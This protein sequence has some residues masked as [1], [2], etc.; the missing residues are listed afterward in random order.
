MPILDMGT[1][2]TA[3]VVGPCVGLPALKGQAAEKKVLMGNRLLVFSVQLC[4]VL[5][6]ERHYFSIENPLGSWTWA[7][8]A[9][10]RLHAMTG[11]VKVQVYY[12]QLGTRHLK[13]TLFL[14]SA[15]ARDPRRGD[16]LARSVLVQGRVE[17]KDLASVTVPAVND[18]VDGE[19]HQREL[20]SE[21]I[22]E[23]T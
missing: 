15:S 7:V 5:H 13:P 6:A 19:T 9:L 21:E 8:A 4:F 3:Q 11:V 12:D 2:T 23:P 20:N 14:H 10:A 18:K 22:C 16:R 1:L 17:V